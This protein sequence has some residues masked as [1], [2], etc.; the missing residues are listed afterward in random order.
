MMDKKILLEIGLTER[1]IAV[2]TALLKLGSI[3]TGP[4]V[5]HSKVPNAKIYEILDKLIKKGLVT[6]F[7]KGK[8]KYFQANSPRNLI[9]FIDNK[10]AILQETVKELE[11]QREEGVSDYKVGIYEGIRAIKSAFFEM[12]DYIGKNSE[13]CVF[14]IGEELGTEKLIQF[15]TEVF[16]K[17]HKMGIKIRTLPNKDLEHIFKKFYS[18]YKNIRIRYTNYKFPT[19]IFIFKD[20]I[21]N[22]IWGE[23]PVAFLTKSEQNYRC[24]KD[25]FE[26]QWKISR[27]D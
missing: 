12:Y 9:N 13:Y 11:M 23:R 24:W 5:K 15:W 25:F 6:Y 21:L 17:R 7:F 27:Y 8:V 4:I 20:H 18:H 26:E 22:V 19:G 16:H 2:Y 14:P 3:T 1:E 10:K